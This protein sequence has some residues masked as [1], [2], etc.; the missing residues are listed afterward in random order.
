MGDVMSN[1]L[2]VL[3]VF[4]VLMLASEWIG[5]GS[6]QLRLPVITGFLAAGVLTGPY[7][8]G[9]LTVDQV[10]QLR[11]VD[12]AALAFI[13]FAAGAELHYRELRLQLRRIGWITLGIVVASYAFVVPAL[14]WAGGSAPFL[15]GM[16]TR[17]RLAVGFVAGAILV[18]RSPSSLMA[19]ISEL[20]ARGPFTRLLMGV[21]VSLDVVVI[22]LFAVG[23][24]VA[25]ALLRATAFEPALILLVGGELVAAAICGAFVAAGLSLAM[26]VG[27]RVP[28]QG[29]LVLAVGLGV[30]ALSGWLRT[31]TRSHGS[32]EVFL[33]PL[34]VCMVAGFAVANFSAYR[35]DFQRV[36]D[37]TGPIVYL[38]FF[39]LAG[40]SLDLSALRLAWRVALLLLVV[41]LLAIVVGSYVGGI[42]G[43]APPQVRRRLWLGMVTQAGIGLGL[44]K[45]V[46]VEF[47]PWGGAFAT[48]MIAVIVVNQVIGPPPAKWV[49][50]R[51]GEARSDLATANLG[52]PRVLIFGLDGQSWALA[53]QLA[54]HGWRPSL[55]SRR[56][57]PA[58][59]PSDIELLHVGDLSA[60]ALLAIHAERART[61]VGLM[62]EEAN[63]ELC[64]LAHEELGVSNVIVRVSTQEGAAACQG[65]G[66][67]ALDPSVAL[68]NL[69]DHFVRSPSMTGLMVGMDL[70]R[71]VI[72]IEVASPDLEGAA[73]RE[74]ALPLDVL[75]LSVRRGGAS[76]VSHGYTRLQRGD[77]VTVMGQRRSL[78]RVA[79]RLAG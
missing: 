24:S 66:A 59:P 48:T 15:Q 39:T 69:F 22:V 67:L 40:A 55:I 71:D 7:V 73:L 4:A 10:Q 14:V 79:D 9:L 50:R 13:A 68:V 26:R 70:D 46:A 75:V 11:I 49:L 27:R 29:L 19:L 57:L 23:T 18:S 44:A 33:E 28:V 74:L 38:A 58:A 20:R 37:A 42:A 56:E 25:E 8:L 1:W 63:I 60:E 17:A 31:A 54:D 35:N 34:L 52:A 5:R 36:L 47:A 12:E 30:Y 41:R 61:L 43:G 2:S 53:R 16:G 78:D 3:A 45:E 62:T 6:R 65:Y 76:L 32:F 72:E 51:S 64:R 77:R 21:T